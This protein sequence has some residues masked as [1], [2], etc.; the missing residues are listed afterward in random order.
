MDL[1]KK[2]KEFK[3]RYASPFEMRDDGIMGMN[4]RNVN[5]IGR[6]NKRSLFPL[7]DNK[8]LTKKIALENHV[9][10]PVLIGSIE[11]QHQVEDIFSIIGEHT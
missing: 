9:N 4:Q 6:Y 1:L 5:Y 10:T 11:N 8:L 2:I 3:N 7:V